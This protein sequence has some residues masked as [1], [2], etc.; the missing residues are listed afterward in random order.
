MET[1]L[2]DIRHAPLRALAA[3]AI[4]R[5]ESVELLVG[6]QGDTRIETIVLRPSLR[7]AQ[8][9][10]YAVT[11]GSWSGERL[12]TEAGGHTMDVDGTCFCRDC[13]TAGGFCVDDD[14]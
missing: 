2:P 12:L 13:E 7:A 8:T 5:G 4:A 14:E 1:N 9:A 6:A 10:G 11:R 3:E